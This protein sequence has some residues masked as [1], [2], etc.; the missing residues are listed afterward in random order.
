M[1]LIFTYKQQYSVYLCLC[2]TVWERERER[3]REGLLEKW[4]NC[5]VWSTWHLYSETL[6]FDLP[7]SRAGKFG[8]LFGLSANKGKE[9][10]CFYSIIPFFLLLGEMFGLD[11]NFL[12]KGPTHLEKSKMARWKYPKRGFRLDPV[13][14]TLHIYQYIRFFFLG[15]QVLRM[16]SGN[17]VSR[18]KT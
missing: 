1:D 14:T 6:L 18:A 2:V 4:E 15:I 17:F 5:H 13:L 12:D 8:I 16:E 9:Q 7:C 10:C 11:L 3:E